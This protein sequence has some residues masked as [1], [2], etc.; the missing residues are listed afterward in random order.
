[1][2]GATNVVRISDKLKQ[3]YS[4][5][6]EY[7][8]IFGVD[9][10]SLSDANCKSNFLVLGKGLTYGINGSFGSPEKKFSINF[11]MANT[12]FCWNLHY[13]SDNSYL[14]VNGKEILKFETKQNK[15]NLSSSVLLKKYI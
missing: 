15:Y 8:V 4:D 14:L 6:D 11:S 10:S 3:V 7:F 5:F 2:F 9:D 1:M 13:D 12:K